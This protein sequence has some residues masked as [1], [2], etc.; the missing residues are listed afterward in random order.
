MGP[1]HR[2]RAAALRFHGVLAPDA[3]WG[4]V[5]TLWVP[6]LFLA[7]LLWWLVITFATFGVCAPRNGTVVAVLFLCALSVSSAL[8]LI[9]ETDGPF[10]GVLRV[11]CDP[12]R[13]ALGPLNQ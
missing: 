1:P 2:S 7:I 10:D 6:P 8:F 3:A 5:L 12:L 11:S 4:S 9:L 13:Y